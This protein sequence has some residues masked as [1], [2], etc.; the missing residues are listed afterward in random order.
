MEGEHK[1]LKKFNKAEDKESVNGGIFLFQK[2][3]KDAKNNAFQFRL[4]PF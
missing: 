3:K 2:R 1:N 4:K